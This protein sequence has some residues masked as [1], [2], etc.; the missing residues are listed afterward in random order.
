M[1]KYLETFTLLIIAVAIYNIHIFLDSRNYDFTDI[2][3]KSIILTVI[4]LSVA[5]FVMINYLR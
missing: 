3:N 2:T 5:T 4:G 1:K